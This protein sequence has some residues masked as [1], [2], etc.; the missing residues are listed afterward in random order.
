MSPNF[1]P[2]YP[3]TEAFDY[4]AAFEKDRRDMQK[5]ALDALFE[6]WK[7]AFLHGPLDSGHSDEHCTTL[8][9]ALGLSKEWEAVVDYYLF[10]TPV[11]AGGVR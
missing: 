7:V 5:Q 6:L 9:A 4:E 10:E 8:A 11:K 3:D 2:E 1:Y